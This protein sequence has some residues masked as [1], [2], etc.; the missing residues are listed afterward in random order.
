MELEA[1]D[2][3]TPSASLALS[4]LDLNSS[5]FAEVATHLGVARRTT[6]PSFLGR[7]RAHTAFV[8][9]LR[10]AWRLPLLERRALETKLPAGDD[11]A[12][13]ANDGS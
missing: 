4:S 9:R 1:G 10:C 8:Q 6:S 13:P 3:T 2:V 5:L 7:T 12:L 11:M